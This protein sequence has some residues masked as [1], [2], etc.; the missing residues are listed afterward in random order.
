MGE[1][2]MKLVGAKQE[3]VL[4]SV[5]G[6]HPE[7]KG[8]SPE[9]AY[10]ASGGHAFRFNPGGAVAGVERQKKGV[11][12]GVVRLG[13]GQSFIAQDAWQG[14]QAGPAGFGQAENQGMQFNLPVHAIGV[15]MRGAFR[16][17]GASDE[18]GELIYEKLAK[19]VRGGRDGGGGCDGGNPKLGREIMIGQLGG[20]GVHDE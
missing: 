3:G 9:H 11:E 8:D 17:A 6:L 5:G 16:L 19:I 2:A 10:H 18:I 7:M 14:R 1:S 20:G 12:C 15:E 4:G 13:K